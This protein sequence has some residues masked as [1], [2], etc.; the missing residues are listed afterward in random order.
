MR[1]VRGIPFAILR[2]TVFDLIACHVS[3]HK[4]RGCIEG[5][6]KNC[7][8]KMSMKERRFS[9]EFPPNSTTV[10]LGEIRP[11]SERP[12]SNRV[13]AASPSSS[14]SASRL[15]KSG[16]TPLEQNTHVFA[17]YHF[18]KPTWCAL[19]GKFIW[20]VSG[21]QGYRCT[22]CKTAIHKTGRCMDILLS[23]SQKSACCRREEMEPEEEKGVVTRLLEKEVIMLHIFSY[24]EATDLASIA[25]VSQYFLSLVHDMKQK[26][27]STP[28]LASMLSTSLTTKRL[29]LGN[30]K[31]NPGRPFQRMLVVT[32]IEAKDLEA[33]DGKISFLRPS[34]LFHA[35]SHSP[36][37]SSSL[38]LLL[39]LCQLR[40]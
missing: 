18:S 12:A 13:S 38:A 17:P 20:G 28:P 26:T 37:S 39:S 24:L 1:V 27:E 25:L 5:V 8:E 16:S 2:L 29:P 15:R 21:K 22:V 3:I 23:S 10:F 32:V 4:G 33:K 19:C 34:S 7:I 6:P 35:F 36:S 40:T 9:T 14:A 11:L 31:S 30:Y